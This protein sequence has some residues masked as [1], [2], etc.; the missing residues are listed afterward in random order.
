[1]PLLAALLL[2]AADGEALLQT[3]REKVAAAP[4]IRVEFRFSDGLRGTDEV[5][6]ELK[7]KGA[8]A[9]ALTM[10][11]GRRGNVETA[12]IL[13][14][15]HRTAAGGAA[16]HD[17][18]PNAARAG[19]LLRSSLADLPCFIGLETILSKRKAEWPAPQV[20]NVKEA[21]RETLDGRE[22]RLLT[23]VL[24]D[25]REGDVGEVRLLLDARTLVP[26]R[27]DMDMKGFRM[28]ETYL[29]FDLD[30]K[31]ADADFVYANPARLAAA[32]AAQAA[33]AVDLFTR[34]TGRHPR[35]LDELAARP[36]DLPADVFWPEGGFAVP[37]DPDGTPYALAR[38]D[39]RLQLGEIPLAPSSGRAIGA[40]TE[41]IRAHLNARVRLAVLASAARA[42]LETY[43][44]IAADLNARPEGL[45]WPAGGWLPAGLPGRDFTLTKAGP[46]LKIQAAE[47]RKLAATPEEIAALDAAAVPRLSDERAAAAARAAGTLGADDL[48]AR[49]VA[50]TELRSLGEAV[51][52]LLEARLKGEQD[53]ETAGRL[54]TILRSIPRSS[55]PWRRE[56][57][58]L[59]TYVGT[60]GAISSN[61][62]NASASLKTLASAQ[63]DFRANDRDGNQI[64]DFWTGDVA[65]LYALQPAGDAAIKLIELSV[66]AA[67][68]APLAKGSAGGLHAGLEKF[69]APSPKA[70]YQFQTMTFDRSATPPEGYQQDT[71]GRLPMGKVHCHSRF[72]FCAFPAEYGATGR[73]TYILNEGNTVFV[74]DTHGEPVL[75]WPTDEELR[76]SWRKLN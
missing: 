27:R 10:T 60:T 7:L 31:L 46:L 61:E 24:R 2:Q 28:S 15:G 51:V 56:L 42:W 64:N 17:S 55:A 41:R 30:A 45:P 70:G 1:M 29:A 58:A 69:A 52:P 3:L 5:R 36:K 44:E 53:V 16:T 12:Y 40:P 39:G 66:A 67:D 32:R 49:L 71:G 68:A 38:K 13:C 72:A 59:T 47:F 76:K 14:D 37:A 33:R 50:E 63:A 22:C 25:E 34:Y 20:A 65:G 75:E 21:A 57:A 18:P 6:G 4:A 9:W 48:D 19:P 11:L 54:R 62:R 23:Y 73:M 43:G 74:G 35:S 8:A 26:V